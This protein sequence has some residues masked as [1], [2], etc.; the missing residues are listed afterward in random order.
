LNVVQ[1][2]AV[3]HQQLAQRAEAAGQHLLGARQ[4]DT[5]IGD[6]RARGAQDADEFEAAV[7][8]G[9]DRRALRDSWMSPLYA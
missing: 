8:S 1:V 3:D 6:V 7:R 4:R 5:D 9:H 2:L